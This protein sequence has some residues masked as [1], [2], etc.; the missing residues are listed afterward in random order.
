MA[1]V[2]SK[3][4]DSVEF[5]AFDFGP[6]LADGDSLAAMVSLRITDGDSAL[7]LSNAQRTNNTIVA[8]F[9]GGTDQS[10]YK[11]EAV[12]LTTLEE[13]LVVVGVLLVRSNLT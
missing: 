1:A 9:A 6:A 13:T 4:P 10:S 11:L 2:T 12:G 7:V 5:F 8:Q 3:H